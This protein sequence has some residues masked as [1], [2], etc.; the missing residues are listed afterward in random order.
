MSPKAPTAFLAFY[1]IAVLCLL[2]GTGTPAQAP[3]STAAAALGSQTA[4]N[5]FKNEDEIRDKFNAWKSDA[6]AQAWLQTMGY[7]VTDVLDVR[8]SKPHGE[9]A[10]VEVF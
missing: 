9:K 7:K 1:F 6:D 8:A 5:G 3:R 2:S 10:D 4:R